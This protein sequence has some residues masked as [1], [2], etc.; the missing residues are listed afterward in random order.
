[1]RQQLQFY[2]RYQETVERRS[3]IP[4]HSH[5]GTLRVYRLMNNDIL[6]REYIVTCKDAV[7]VVHRTRKERSKQA[8]LRTP[9]KGKKGIEVCSKQ[10]MVSLKYFPSM[11]V[12]TEKWNKAHVHHVTSKNKPNLELLE[13]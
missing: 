3:A 10:V 12:M 7:L 8:M 5:S 9:K 13:D 2:L 6:K 1:L 4:P 11:H